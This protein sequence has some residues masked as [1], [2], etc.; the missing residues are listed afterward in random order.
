MTSCWPAGALLRLRHQPPPAYS[1]TCLNSDHCLRHIHIFRV[2]LTQESWNTWE[3]RNFISR[4]SLLWK[5]SFLAKVV[6]AGLWFGASVAVDGRSQQVTISLLLQPFTP[7][8]IM[9]EHTQ[10]SF[11]SSTID[12]DKKCKFWLRKIWLV[13]YRVSH[14]HPSTQFFSETKVTGRTR[15]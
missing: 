6:K 13:F 3:I 15:N 8:H 9:M 1:T 4:D 11:P 2:Q 12:E 10:A 14:N 5:P 7:S